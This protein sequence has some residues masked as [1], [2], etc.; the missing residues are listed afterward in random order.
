M[1]LRILNGGIGGDTAYDMN[2]R[3]D[4]DIFPMKP[5]V[6]MEVTFGMNDSGYFEY[7]GDNPK[8]FGEQKYQESIKN[9]QQM[10]KRFKDLPDTR[11]VS[12]FLMMKPCN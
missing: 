2:K 5:S 12:N 11:I 7:N 6:L 4:G 1:P 9:Y 8:E 10:E 3:L